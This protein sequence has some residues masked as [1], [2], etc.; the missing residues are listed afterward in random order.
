MTVINEFSLWSKIVNMR[1][2]IRK[3]VL[4]NHDG[5]LEPVTERSTELSVH[6]VL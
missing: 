1:F 5:L 3:S 2:L 6:D 4:T